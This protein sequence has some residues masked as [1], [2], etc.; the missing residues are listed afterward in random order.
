MI[1]LLDTCT[2][3][4]LSNGSSELSPTAREVLTDGSNQLH[5]S[6]VS[7]WEIATKIHKRKLQLHRPIAEWLSDIRETYGLQP[8]DVDDESALHVA[9]LPPAHSDPFDRM[10]VAQAIVHG[11]VLLTPD[12]EITQYSARTLW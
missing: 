8:L 12:R 1:V 4:W 6:A 3:L 9:R 2:A 11:L 5:L 7:V 10:L